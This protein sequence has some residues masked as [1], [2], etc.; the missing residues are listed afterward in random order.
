[1]S[2]QPRWIDFDAESGAAEPLALDKRRAHAAEEV[3]DH[4]A[5]S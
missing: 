2:V 1:M 3:N 5:A 4:L